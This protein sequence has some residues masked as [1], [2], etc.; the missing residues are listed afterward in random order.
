MSLRV[1]LTGLA[2][3]LWGVT[4]AKASLNRAF[5]SVRIDPK[6]RDLTMSRLNPVEIQGEDR[7]V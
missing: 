7:T 2:N 5:L 6:P 3:P 1:I 4:I